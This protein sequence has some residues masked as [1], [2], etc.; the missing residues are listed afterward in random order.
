MLGTEHAAQ[1]ELVKGSHPYATVMFC[2]MCM[3]TAAVTSLKHVHVRSNCAIVMKD[4]IKLI[5]LQCFIFSET[6]LCP[7][8]D[9]GMIR[10]GRR[11]ENRTVLETCSNNVWGVFCVDESWDDNAAVVACRQLGYETGGISS[12]IASFLLS[13]FNC[14]CYTC[15]CICFLC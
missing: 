11:E 3:E 12:T 5:E 8:N 6:S 1:V 2:V 4:I 7:N 14:H 15:R 13:S 9:F 10:L